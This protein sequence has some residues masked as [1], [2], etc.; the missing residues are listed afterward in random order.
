VSHCGIDTGQDKDNRQQDKQ[1]HIME[2]GGGGGGSGLGLLASGT[3][4]DSLPTHGSKN[5]RRGSGVGFQARECR[6]VCT[7]ES[8][9]IRHPLATHVPQI[10][11]V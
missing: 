6:T 10:K 11:S 3:P 9:R 7:A 8:V 1:W 4:I 2:A 5:Q